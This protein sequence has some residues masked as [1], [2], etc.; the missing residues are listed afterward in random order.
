MPFFLYIRAGNRVARRLWEKMV[1]SPKFTSSRE[2]LTVGE[3]YI[4]HSTSRG[5]MQLLL[6]HVRAIDLG[7]WPADGTALVT[8]SAG[9]STSSSPEWR[10]NASSTPATK[11][12]MHGRASRFLISTWACERTSEASS[13]GCASALSGPY[14]H[15]C[16]C[17]F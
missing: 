9:P 14:I 12:S 5:D 7:V 10:A 11:T 15:S 1:L 6:A 4:P 13:E 3:F 2:R 16:P 17:K 8:K